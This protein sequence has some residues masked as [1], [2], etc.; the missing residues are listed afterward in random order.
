MY[1]YG[2]RSVKC[3]VCERVNAVH[4]AAMP[5][6]AGLPPGVSPPPPGASAAPP[7]AAPGA[8]AVGPPVEAPVVV[9]N[10]STVD[11]KG[12]EVRDVPLKERSASQGPPCVL[13]VNS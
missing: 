9:Q 4:Q 1:S 7:A 8:A 2:A 3:A 10:P 6:Q 13:V 5:G 12:N 11:E